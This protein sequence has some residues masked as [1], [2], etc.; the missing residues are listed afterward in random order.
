MNQKEKNLILLIQYMILAVLS[1]LTIFLP[2]LIIKAEVSIYATIT[3]TENYTGLDLIRSLPDL[4]S[5]VDSDLAAYTDLIEKGS[6]YMRALIIIC[7]ILPL[8]L[9]FINMV[10]H[11]AAFLR[12]KMSRLYA[13]LPAIAFF[14]AAAGQII[15]IIGVHMEVKDLKNQAEDG[16]SSIPIFGSKLNDVIQNSI[17]IK[18]YPHAGFF[19]FLLLT[20]ILLLEDLLLMY[21]I[22]ESEVQAPA[23]K[24]QPRLRAPHFGDSRMDP[25]QAG[26]QEMR[27]VT[28]WTDSDLFIHSDPGPISAPSFPG[29][30]GG[31]LIGV[32]GEYE[33]AR[34]PIESGEWIEIGRDNICNLILTNPRVSRR[35]CR[36][37]YQAVEDRYLLVNDS[38]NGTY[39]PN[40]E[41]LE[42]GRVCYLPR[43]TRFLVSR[44][45]EFRLL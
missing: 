38:R 39:L 15:F 24:G 19:I 22:R 3:R 10:L 16:L 12:G 37:S 5:M 25:G 14:L 29:I 13:I 23:L 8:I 32:R 42:R 20:L 30:S 2:W 21:R 31:M 33:S 45:D 17:T 44:E 41:L 34:I 11:L 43:G 18:V 4:K 35:H 40:G 26:R 1:L 6:V 28:T 27:T 9:I 7:L 36:V